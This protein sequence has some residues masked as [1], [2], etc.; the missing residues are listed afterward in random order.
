MICRQEFHN[1]L[2]KDI[3]DFKETNIIPNPFFFFFFNLGPF[4]RIVLC[5]WK[6]TAYIFWEIF[7]TLFPLKGKL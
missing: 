2:Q 3:Y 4:H 6:Q 5:A 1:Q 7:Y